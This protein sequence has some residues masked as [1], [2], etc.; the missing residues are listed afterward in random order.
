[1][2]RREDSGECELVH[3]SSA[4]ESSWWLLVSECRLQGKTLP[5]YITSGNRSHE[6]ADTFMLCFPITLLTDVM[7]KKRCEAHDR[8]RGGGI[9]GGGVGGS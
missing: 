9:L 3:H 7:S 1:M 6:P 4:E 5:T 8:S 2:G